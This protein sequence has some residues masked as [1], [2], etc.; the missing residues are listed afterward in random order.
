MPSAKII[1]SVSNDIKLAKTPY[2]GLE[3]LL[4]MNVNNILEFEIANGNC[5]LANAIR[6][7]LTSEMP[8]K[9]FTVS[10][11]DIVTTDPYVIGEVIRKRIEMIP[12]SQTIDPELVFAIKYENKTDECVDVNSDDIKINGVGLCKDIF[13]SI[14]VCTINSGTS[15]AIN[16]IH[17]VESYGYDNARCSIGRVA[18][19][20]LDQDFTKSSLLTEP[21]KFRIELEVAG[22]LKPVKL[23]Q[24]AIDSL[25][26]RLNAID[27]GNAISEFGIYKLTINN[28]THSI[29]RLLSWY[30]YQLEPSIKYCASRIPHPSKR[31]CVLDIHHPSGEDLCKKAIESIKK[32]LTDIRKAFA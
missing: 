4:P 15:F 3:N 20:I 13:P 31:E 27:Y 29:G 23:V 11:T 5:A 21:S 7:T 28:E 25:L 2:A 12:V 14:P 30:I 17:V 26:H 18:Y 32:D 6:R 22:V 9:H 19:E 24:S 1:R 10:L 16:D 8:I